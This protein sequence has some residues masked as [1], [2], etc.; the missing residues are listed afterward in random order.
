MLF[1]RALLS[2]SSSLSNVIAS[3]APAPAAVTPNIVANLLLASICNARPC[4]ALPSLISLLPLLKVSK[5]STNI[6]L[7]L[8]VISVVKAVNV[9]RPVAL[10]GQY[11]YMTVYLV[12]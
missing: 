7:V 8:R 2:S 6:F 9:P 1:K 3:I 10:A 11:S 12:S 5:E 4:L